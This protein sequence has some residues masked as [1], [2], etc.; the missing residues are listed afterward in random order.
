M[1]KM[2]NKPKVFL[3]HSKADIQFIDRIYTD[4]KK[5]QIDPWRDSEEIRH[6]KPWLDAIFEHGLPTCDCVLVYFT[7]NSLKSKMVRKEIDSGIL[8]KLKDSGI[9]FLP[10][11]S[12]AKVRDSLRIDIR[13]LQTPE[14]NDRNYGVLLPQ[15]VAEIWR[16]YLERVVQ[17]VQQKEKVMRLEAEL[18]LEKI[19]NRGKIFSD[20]EELDFKHIQNTFNREVEVLIEEEVVDA[21]DEKLTRKHTFIINLYS[22]IVLI[23]EEHEYDWFSI[24]NVLRKNLIPKKNSEKVEKQER[25]YKKIELS[26]NPEIELITFGL[27]HRIQNRIQSPAQSDP[28]GIFRTFGSPYTLIFTDKMHRFRYWLSYNNLMSTKIEVFKSESD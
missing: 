12:E 2:S 26:I 7:P 28:H 21:Y 20:S 25:N 9:S 15:V 22:L 1:S 3:S 16:S 14:W 13:A 8:Q 17:E 10:Y 4:L 18:Q 5:C 27:L 23:S 6:G 11:V 24:R 19:R